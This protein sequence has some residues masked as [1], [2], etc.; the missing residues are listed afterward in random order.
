MIAG[1]KA[2]YKGLGS[3]NG[4]QGCGFMLTARDAKRGAP[5]DTFRIKTWDVASD[6][7]VLDNGSNQA[8]GGSSIVIHNN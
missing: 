2:Q 4:A 1:D 8:R 5:E 7:D 6:A 3:I